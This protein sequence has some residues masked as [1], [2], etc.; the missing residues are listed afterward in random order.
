[1]G[2][3]AEDD[4]AVDGEG[5]A[6]GEGAAEPALDHREDGLDL[7]ALSIGAL[8]EALVKLLSVAACD[9]GIGLA[10]ETASSA[11]GRG[12]DAGYAK[13]L[14]ALLMDPLALVACVG[15][16][17]VELV[18]CESLAESRLELGVIEPRAAIDNSAED[19]VALRVADGGKLWPAV[20]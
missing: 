8:G 4:L 19:H 13:L 6:A 1:M 3:D 7:P 12:N 17:G 20:L 5:A 14:P 18:S 11:E 9:G 16:K 10:V 15:K 2:N